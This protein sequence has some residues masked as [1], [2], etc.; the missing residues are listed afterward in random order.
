MAILIL[1]IIL[2]IGTHSIRIVAPG[3][4]AAMVEKNGLKGWRGFYSLASIVSLVLLIWGYATAPVVNVWF[5]PVW[6]AHVAV[7]LMLISMVCFV[8]SSMPAGYIATK[9]KHPMVLGVKIWATAHLLANG[10]LA[11]I[12]LFGAFLVWGVVMRISLKGRERAGEAVLRPFV[13]ARYDLQATVVGVV[14]WLV[15]LLKLHEWLIGV[16][17]IPAMSL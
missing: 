6:T 1:G 17:P 2:F 7:T 3:L 11:S 16:A 13:S 10:D 5:P 9:T 4:R 12:L 8:A 15:F 14:I